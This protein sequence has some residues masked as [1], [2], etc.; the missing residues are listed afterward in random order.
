M[1]LES[2]SY[3][4]LA[5]EEEIRTG[6]VLEFPLQKDESSRYLNLVYNKNYQLPAAAEHLIR[7]VKDFYPDA[8]M[9]K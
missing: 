2:R 9:G 7:I 4:K 5:A 1:G 6:Q 3:Q 8:H